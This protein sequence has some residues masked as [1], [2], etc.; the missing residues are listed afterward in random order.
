MFNQKSTTMKA[1]HLLGLMVLMQSCDI[2]NEKQEINPISFSKTTETTNTPKEV[3]SEIVNGEKY[4][5]EE[6]NNIS[7][8]ADELQNYD[9]YLPKSSANN[10]EKFPVIILF[11]GGGWSEGDK[12]FISPMV[13]HL[14]QKNVRCAIVNANYRLTFKSGITYRE[15]LDDIR[16]IINKLSNEASSLNIDPRFC[17]MGISAGGHLAMLYAYT[18]NTSGAVKVVGGIIPPVDLTTEK[19]R[20]GRMDSDITKLVGKPFDG[21][22]EAYKNA[23]PLY[24]MKNNSTPTIAFFGGK[25]TVVPSEQ[26]SAFKAKLVETNTPHEYKLYQDQTHEWSVLPETL[27]QT[28]SFIDK[29]L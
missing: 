27:D 17:L 15:Q 1:I 21:N 20:Q 26:G 5:Y 3:N 11:H 6:R 18:L 13:D 19:I 9:L 16:A 7:Y 22:L 14:K 10:S 29:Y 2:I 23:S 8:R 25:D 24:Q 12:G 4:T 28:I